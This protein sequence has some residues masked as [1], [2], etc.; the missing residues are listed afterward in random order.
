LSRIGK[1][2]LPLPL[3]AQ[4]SMLKI[5]RARVYKGKVSQETKFND[6][7]PIFIEEKNISQTDSSFLVEVT[8]KTS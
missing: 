7:K 1:H 3:K 4:L 5:L 8:G 2:F 6:V